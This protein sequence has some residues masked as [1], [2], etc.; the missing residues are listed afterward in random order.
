M[1]ELKN[2]YIF[3]IYIYTH[4]HTY[5][6]IYIYIYTHTHIHTHVKTITARQA[7]LSME[8]SRQEY[9]SKWPFPS[10]GDLPDPGTELR[11]PALQADSLLSEPPGRPLWQYPVLTST[12]SDWKSYTLLVD[13]QN[14]AVASE[15]SY[16]VFIKLSIHLPYNP[17]ILLPKLFTQI[18]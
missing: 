3:Y 13:V 2:I 4:I 5:I 1:A 7:F 17:V 9:W 8:F 12:Q 16:P 18:K 15:N 10:P 6:Y 11:A 14:Y